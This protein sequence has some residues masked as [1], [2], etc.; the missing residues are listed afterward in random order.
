MRLTAASA[1]AC[2]GSS[3]GL[4][5]A[6]GTE[7]ASSTATGRAGCATVPSSGSSGGASAGR[8][9]FPPATA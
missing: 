5:M 4:A 3:R 9:R 6:W 7:S 8:A 2:A 1:R